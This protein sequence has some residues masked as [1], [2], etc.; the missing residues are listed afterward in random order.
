MQRPDSQDQ[1]LVLAFKRTS[2]KPFKLFPL[3]SAAACGTRH[4]RTQAGP[5]QGSWTFRFRFSQVESNKEENSRRRQR[6]PSSVSV[7]LGPPIW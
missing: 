6:L 1:K 3:R 2:L 5:S 7:Y 4:I